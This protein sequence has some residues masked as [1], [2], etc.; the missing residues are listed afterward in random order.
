[1]TDAAIPRPATR[2]A[3]SRQFEKTIV[4]GDFGTYTALGFRSA[5]V[6]NREGRAASG[7]AGDLHLQV[8]RKQL[9]D[10]SREF[11]RDNAIYKGLIE[12]ATSYIIGGGF[13]LQVHD[14]GGD[15]HKAVEKQWRR[16]WRRPE[17]RGILSGR[18]VQ[19]MICRELLTCGDTLALKL[20]SKKLQL[21]ESEQLV[22]PGY[23]G[24]GIDKDANGT[25]T[26]F[27]IGTYTKYGNIKQAAEAEKPENVIFI[28]EPDRPSSTRGAP[29]S[30]AAFP[31]VHRLNDICDSEAIA[32]QLLARIAMSVTREKGSELAFNESAD[33]PGKP[34][35]A[36]GDVGMRI[37]QYDFALLFHGEP[38]DEIKGVER[39]IPGA[40]FNEEVRIFL[41]LLGLPLGLPLEVILLD[42]TQTNYSQSRAV[43]EQ[44]F[45]MFLGWQ[46]LIEEFFLRPV[47]E[48]QLEVWRAA[49]TIPE[50]P[51]EFDVETDLD[52]IK[53]TF[54]WIDQL[55][56]IQAYG[57][58]MDRCVITHS[59]VCKSRNADRDDV[60]AQREKEIRD[61]ID[62]AQKILKDTGEA[63]PWQLFA[64]VTLPGTAPK[65]AAPD[66]AP[67]ADTP[68]KDREK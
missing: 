20:K 27:R 59:G 19:K 48:W 62:R 7:G 10:Q 2:T 50:P 60:V 12:R 21:L 34:Q 42:W 35:P 66:E 22:G 30:Q 51:K 40:S 3:Q 37:E 9:V 46:L 57:D 16:F 54:P 41:R 6:A 36:A 55:K 24:D 56:E 14:I 64:G 13:Q 15:W 49:G 11:M 26:G 29:P 53:P 61:A 58:E 5:R 32:R 17:N 38:G 45:Q 67:A 63:V 52:W 68:A 8:S 31:M 18:G 1:M 43:L 28:T 25:P 47:F 39:N 4:S 23:L 44:A 65:A 33:D